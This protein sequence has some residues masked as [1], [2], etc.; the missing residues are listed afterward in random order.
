MR[1]TF[2][3]ATAAAGA[4][5]LLL[6]F[7]FTPSAKADPQQL[8]GKAAPDFTL[9][10]TSGQTVKLSALKG[11]VVLVDFWATWCPPCRAS[12]PHVQALSADASKAKEGLIVLAVN[13]REDKG[14]I[15]TFTTK[16]KF[17]F[18]V[19]MDAE[20]AT[21]GAYGVRGIPTTV[22]IGRDGTVKKVFV[23]FGGEQ[24]AKAIDSAIEAALGE[25]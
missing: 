3:A 7:T 16:N 15:E 5:A 22:V 18:P 21:M 14:T 1:F 4:L 24:S 13:A 23:G 8:T 11:K 20:G 6:A 19:P 25:K 2:N 12:L 17:S 10:M 9:K